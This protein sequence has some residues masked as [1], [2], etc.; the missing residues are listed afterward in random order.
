M[1][2]HTARSCPSSLS[3]IMCCQTRVVTGRS[4]LAS[5]DSRRHAARLCRLARPRFSSFRAGPRCVWSWFL[6]MF[7][8]ECVMWRLIFVLFVP[9]EFSCLRSI[10][11][12]TSI[13]VSFRSCS[14]SGPSTHHTS[15]FKLVPKNPGSITPSPRLLAPPRRSSFHFAVCCFVEAAPSDRRHLQAITLH[16]IQR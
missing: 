4:L 6:E 12:V 10:A 15:T 13:L 9:S 16:F 11:P 1:T 8:G 3:L 5:F 2:C 14:E 7:L